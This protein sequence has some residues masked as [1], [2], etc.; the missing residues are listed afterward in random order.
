MYLFLNVT[1]YSI[2]QSSDYLNTIQNT[3]QAICIP[4]KISNVINLASQMPHHCYRN[5][6]LWLKLDNRDILYFCVISCLWVLHFQ[7]NFNNS[8]STV[9]VSSYT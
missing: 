8:A 1:V 7:I 4:M 9:V 3:N 6:C 5:I 2:N